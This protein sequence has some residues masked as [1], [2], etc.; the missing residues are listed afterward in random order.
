MDSPLFLG[1]DVSTQSCKAVVVDENLN[2]V[3]STSLN[4]DKDLPQYHTINGV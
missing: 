4:F 3:F 1:F 2:T